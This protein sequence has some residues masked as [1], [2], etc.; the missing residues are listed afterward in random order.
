MMGDPPAKG[1]FITITGV[2]KSFEWMAPPLEVI[3]TS[4]Y[5]FIWCKGIAAPLNCQGKMTE[6]MTE[7]TQKKY[8]QRQK[9]LIPSGWFPG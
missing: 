2:E 3:F 6:K 7:K 4:E 9:R 5:T 8:P 1:F